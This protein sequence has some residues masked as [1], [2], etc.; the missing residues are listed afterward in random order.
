MKKKNLDKIT[1]SFMC[2]ITDCVFLKFYCIH[3]KGNKIHSNGKDSL[4]YRPTV[5]SVHYFLGV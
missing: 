5:L 1:S 4:D 2:C 3:T